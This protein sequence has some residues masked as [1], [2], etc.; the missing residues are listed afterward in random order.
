[1]RVS[2]RWL[3]AT[4]AA[5]VVSRAGGAAE[6]KPEA[7][8]AP[9][10]EAT[11]LLADFRTKIPNIGASGTWQ[12]RIGLSDNGFVVQGGLGADGKGDMGQ[13]LDPALDLSKEKYIEVALGVGAKNEVPE[14]TIAFDDAEG[15]QFTARI[16]INQVLPQQAVW[17]RVRLTD[18]KLNDWQGNKAGRKIDWTRIKQWHLQGDWSTAAPFHVMFIALRT[19]Q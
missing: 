1:M 2:C 9:P 6:T 18:F 3:L 17:F 12:G 7:A 19:R 15:T 13:S 10:P 8:I 14:V 11:R 5:L 16:R 4:V